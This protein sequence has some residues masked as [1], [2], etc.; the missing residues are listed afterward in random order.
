M[1]CKPTFI[2]EFSMQYHTIQHAPQFALPMPRIGFGA[3]GISD[4]YGSG[5]DAA[6]IQ[7]VQTAVGHGITHFDTADGYG[8]GANERFLQRALQLSDYSARQRLIIASKAGIVRDQ[9]D[10]GLRGVN[11]TPVY[12]QA[13][14]QNSLRNLG[15]NYLDIFYIHRLPPAAS[16]SELRTLAAFLLELK[17]SALAR[18]IG[19]S[20]P[21]LAQLQFLH[22]ICPLSFVQSEYSLLERGA[23]QNGVLDYCRAQQI[24]FVAYSP[25]CRGM[26]SDSFDANALEA[27]DFRRNL[28]RFS[29]ENLQHNSMI[30]AGLK[31]LAE[32]KQI[33]LSSLALAWLLAQGVL[34]IPGMR[35]AS[36]VQDALL[37]EQTLLSADELAEIDKIAYAGAVQGTRYTP[38]AMAVY[39]LE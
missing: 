30:V 3:M 5:D 23:E 31:K 11:I 28:P 1:L 15:T 20:E 19:V 36:R 22:D 26:L 24:S 10:P 38:A 27:S 39:G 6:A 32:A 17:Q 37:A 34:V 13:Q 9:H 29:G 21:K 8:F 25:L 2:Q 16:E 14:L 12:L 33:P 18:A 7:A 35:K 4:F